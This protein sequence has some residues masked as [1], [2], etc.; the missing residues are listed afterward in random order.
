M[1]ALNIIIIFT[2]CV[3]IANT[4]YLSFHAID[5]SNVYCLGFPDEWCKKVQ[6]S[7]Y[8]RTF[9]IK[10]PYLGLGMLLVIAVLYWAWQDGILD[11]YYYFGLVTFGF[12]FSCYFLYIQAAVIKAFCTWCVLSFLVFTGLFVA[13]TLLHHA[14]FFG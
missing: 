8:S 4:M 5:G 6:Y 10:N 14:Q 2:I 3:G 13:G 7:P 1:E 11:Y 9:G 12:L